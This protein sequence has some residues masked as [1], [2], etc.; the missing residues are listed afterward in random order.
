M[1]PLETLAYL[2][3]VRTGKKVCIAPF[4]RLS[5]PHADRSAS[6]AQNGMGC[7]YCTP[8]HRNEKRPAVHASLSI[9]NTANYGRPETYC[10]SVTVQNPEVGSV[11]CGV[12]SDK[13]PPLPMFIAPRSVVTV[14]LL[15][16]PP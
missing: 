7:L 10:G 3:D 16:T 15:T 13:A 14:P 1:T 12:G 9:G 6:L 4:P 11:N 2:S 8:A 5:N